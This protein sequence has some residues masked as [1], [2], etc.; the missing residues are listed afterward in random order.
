MELGVGRLDLLFKVGRVEILGSVRQEVATQTH[1]HVNHPP[2]VRLE[3]RTT[4]YNPVISMTAKMHLSHWV[5]NIC[6][7]SCMNTLDLLTGT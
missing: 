7:S 2:R 6:P 1:K 4:T 5:L 3:P